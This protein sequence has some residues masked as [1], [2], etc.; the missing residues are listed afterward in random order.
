MSLSKIRL[1]LENTYG[2]MHHTSKLAATISD[3]RIKRWRSF[4]DTGVSLSVLASKHAFV[5][6]N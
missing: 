5:S 3:S 1:I 6:F 4:L 2:H